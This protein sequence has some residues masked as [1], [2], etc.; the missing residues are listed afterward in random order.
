MPSRSIKARVTDVVTAEQRSRLVNSFEQRDAKPEMI[1]RHGLHA[2]GL[3]FNLQAR[4]LPG[5]PDLVFAG[6]RTAVS[7][8][9]SFR[10][11]HGCS[12]SKVPGTRIEFWKQKL[13]TNVARA[14]AVFRALC[15]AGWL[16][17]IVWEC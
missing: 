1:V 15:E 4:S 8:H 5:R 7:P 13:D 17:V 6:Y 14:H 12:L 9:G 10:H 11:A 2:M 16:V 3:R